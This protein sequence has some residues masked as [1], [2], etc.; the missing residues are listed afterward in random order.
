[1]SLSK[2]VL[3]G[4]VTSAVVTFVVLM[5]AFTA[6]LDLEVPGVVS[7]DSTSEAG[8][9]ATNLTF[10]PLATVLLA[11]VLAVLLWG[12]GRLRSRRVGA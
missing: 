3:W 10:N 1:M 9:P 11:L 8:A 4:F 5:V 2:A 7:V 6:R 12:A